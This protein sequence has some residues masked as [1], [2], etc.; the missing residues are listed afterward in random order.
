[1]TIVAEILKSKLDQTVYKIAPGVSV[2][3][4]LRQMADRNIGALPVVYEGKIIGMLSERYPTDTAPA[5]EDIRQF[6]TN[7][8]DT[9]PSWNYTITPNL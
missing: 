1:M 5:P 2:F 9:L 8:H 7:P 3:D 6:H 4:A